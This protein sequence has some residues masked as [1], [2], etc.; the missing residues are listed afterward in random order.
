[1]EEFSLDKVEEMV[2]RLNPKSVLVEGMA[3]WDLLR[4]HLGFD[5]ECKVRRTNARLLCV[6]KNQD[7]IFT[8]IIHPSTRV[9]DENWARVRSELLPLLKG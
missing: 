6:S 1:M 7:P 5:D 9:S 4:S 3:T 2:E 8:G